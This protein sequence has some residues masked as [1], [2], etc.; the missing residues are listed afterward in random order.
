MESPQIIRR[1]VALLSDFGRK[2]SDFLVA[3]RDREKQGHSD[4]SS[5]QWSERE[6]EIRMLAPR[7]EAAIEASGVEGYAEL[8]SVILAFKDW[9]GFSFDARDDD[10]Q[11]EILRLIPSQVAG[12][13]M[14]LEEAEARP[15]K[16]RWRLPTLTGRIRH[17]PP[18]LGFI[19]DIG[20]TIAVIVVLG[21]LVGAW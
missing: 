12:L 17:V 4:W 15:A 8:S 6:L 14:R 20:G 3:R 1:H 9:L 18:V 13:E 10:L 5:R 2:Y 16:S 21:H 11:I 19:A 7:A